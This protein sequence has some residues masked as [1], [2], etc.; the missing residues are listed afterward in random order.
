[1][2]NEDRE[3]S[4]L[5]MGPICF[6]FLLIYLYMLRLVQLL[7][8]SDIQLGR[9]DTFSL[10]QQARMELVI[11]DVSEYSVDDFLD[12]EGNFTDCC[13]WDRNVCDENEE[14]IDINFGALDGTL[15]LK[16][17][18]LTVKTITIAPSDVEGRLCTESLP[19]GLEELLVV[20]TYFY[21]FV[22]LSSLPP[23]I[24]TVHL[25]TNAFRGSVCLSA[26]PATIKLLDLQ[27]NRFLGPISLDS[28]PGKLEVL[29]LS[30]NL[31]C[32][33]VS[34]QELPA[35]LRELDLSF[36]QII[37]SIIIDNV[38]EA[39]RVIALNDNNFSGELQVRCPMSNVQYLQ[40]QRNSL[41]GVAVL[42]SALPVT[43]EM[44]NNDIEGAVDE[45]GEAYVCTLNMS[46]DITGVCER[47]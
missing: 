25:S 46:G 35:S 8:S 22:N 44:Y 7:S 17:I 32:G 27:S 39:M 18:P 9:F 47:K 34:L 15:N 42:H 30:H 29:R 10:T 23:N 3:E 33:S 1:M 4:H 43:L 5:S 31:F 11:Q 36:N 37:G 21:G 19:E 45:N 38:S 6:T 20:N 24:H 41:T 40:V 2:I 13:D 26:L 12:E 28:L 16:Y 14:L